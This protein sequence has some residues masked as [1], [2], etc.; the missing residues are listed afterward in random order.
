MN[1]KNFLQWECGRGRNFMHVLNLGLGAQRFPV[2][3][4]VTPPV[5]INT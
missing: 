1:P 5:I 3:G 4:D 2:K